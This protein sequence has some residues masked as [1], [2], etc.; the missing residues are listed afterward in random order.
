M[1]ARIA[2]VA[3]PLA[4]GALL[5][6][7]IVGGAPSESQAFF[8]KA[9]LED[10]ATTSGVKRLLRTDA[11]MVDPRSGFVDV[12]GDG[13]QDALVLVST[14]GAGGTVAFYVFSTDGAKADAGEDPPLRVVHRLQSLYRATLR[15]SGQTVTV[16]EPAWRKGDDLCCPGKLREREYTWLGGDRNTFRRTADRTVDAPAA[17]ETP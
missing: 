12:T 10:D 16:V 17:A 7:A 13:K 1:R 14:G 4:A 5:V 11:G 3:A 2:L 15:V 8:E 6:P 9:L